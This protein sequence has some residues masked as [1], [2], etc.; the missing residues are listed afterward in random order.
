MWPRSV[1]YGQALARPH[2][3]AVH[4]TSTDINGVPLT[5]DTAGAPVVRDLPF[6]T[7]SVSAKI[8]NRVTRST[9]LSFAESWWPTGPDHP[10]SSEWAVLHITGGLK[11][12]NGNEELFPLFVGRVQD[13]E[14]DDDGTV[15]VR[16]DD[17]AADVIGY[18]FEQLW[19]VRNPNSCLA[20]IRA[21]ILDALPQATFTDGNV[22]DAPVPG[23]LTFDD[24]RGKALDDLADA[25]GARWYALGNG[26][27][28]VRASP[29]AGAGDDP[30][31]TIADGP[32]GL[33]ST[34]RI[35]STRDGVTNSVTVLSERADGT[36]P[37]RSTSRDTVSSSPTRFGGLFGRTGQVIKVQTPLTQ[38]QAKTLSDA[39]LRAGVAL[40]QQ[41]D[42]T[43]VPDYSLEPAD[44]AR[45]QSRGLSSVQV[46]D[47]ITY[48]LTTGGA[49]SIGG[50]ALVPATITTG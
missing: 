2:Q 44:V 28:T 8:T 11:Y 42:I 24:D 40:A 26:S 14:R 43:C 6:S 21:I 5:R 10:L 12:G 15:T 9:T 4:V 19:S 48:P 49:Q 32:D 16:A 41:W 34:A 3:L 17:L 39:E 23:S 38:S 22:T 27:F 33:L 13:V 18:P 35:H 29:Y 7:G 31:V 37:V 36:S 30:D 25:L 45:V 1:L 47:T 20:E 50:R 46:I